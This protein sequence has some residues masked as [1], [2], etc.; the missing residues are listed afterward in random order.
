[1]FHWNKHNVFALA[2]DKCHFQETRLCARPVFAA[3]T[4]SDEPFST[5]K[6]P[7]LWM[8]PSASLEI[9]WEE[10]KR[11][12]CLGSLTPDRAWLAAGTHVQSTITAEFCS[13]EPRN[14]PSMRQK[15]GSHYLHIHK[16]FFSDPLHRKTHLSCFPCIALPSRHL[17]RSV[18][19]LCR[20]TVL[21]GIRAANVGGRAKE[22]RRRAGKGTMW[23]VHNQR[24]RWK[25]WVGV[26]NHFVL[27]DRDDRDFCAFFSGFAANGSALLAASLHLTFSRSS[28]AEKATKPFKRQ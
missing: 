5:L 12:T 1:M 23:S 14:H 7:A 11:E 17:Y 8:A 18:S 16:F 15:L 9:S 20:S 13:E 26:K 3:C 10:T 24:N 21:A 22:M 27:H 28:L 19:P 6:R 4:S 2:A 25:C